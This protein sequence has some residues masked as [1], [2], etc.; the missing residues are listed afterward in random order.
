MR[1]VTGFETAQKLLD[2]RA[3]ASDVNAVVEQSVRAVIE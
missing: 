2:R 1:F 3:G